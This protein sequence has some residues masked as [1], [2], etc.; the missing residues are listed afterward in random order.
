MRQDLRER[1]QFSRQSILTLP[2]CDQISCQT[3]LG[4]FP[5][6]FMYTPR[7]YNLFCSG[8]NSKYA[9]RSCHAVNGF[10][11]NFFIF[12][13]ERRSPW[14][15]NSNRHGLMSFYIHE[16]VSTIHVAKLKVNKFDIIVFGNTILFPVAGLCTACCIFRSNNF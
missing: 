5:F 4:L 15:E 12:S 16:L 6:T 11:F 2:L 1:F 9:I 7:Q 13:F 10:E 8:T 14:N 3:S